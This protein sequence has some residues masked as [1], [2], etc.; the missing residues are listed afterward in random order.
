MLPDD[1]AFRS[2]VM[3]KRV[4]AVLR[5]S[6]SPQSANMIRCMIGDR[7]KNVARY[8]HQLAAL[9][10]LVVTRAEGVKAPCEYLLCKNTGVI[11]PFPGPDGLLMPPTL[12]DLV[13][14]AMKPMARFTGP[15]MQALVNIDGRSYR[16]ES[17]NRVLARLA[18][19]GYLICRRDGYR[20]TYI[21]R[22]HTGP[23]A[24][25]LARRATFDL[26]TEAIV[27][28]A[29]NQGESHEQD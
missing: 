28:T 5:G 19:A 16:P 6:K 24:P 9:N 14:R 20:R 18:T 17:V 8:L 26:N 13:W 1:R 22:Q 2:V 3:R 27:W 29:E 25:I 11:A 4:W 12:C 21:L 15:E 7:K 23:Y 10:Y